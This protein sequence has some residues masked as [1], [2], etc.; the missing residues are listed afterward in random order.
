MTLAIGWDERSAYWVS[1]RAYFLYTEGRCRESLA[2]LEG[3]MEL[4]PDNL[5]YKDSAS[6]LHL[7][8]GNPGQAIRYAS[9]VISADPENI[10]ALVRRC[11]G[12]L[13]LGKSSEAR[14]DVARMNLLGATLHVRRIEMRLQVVE[15]FGRNSV[16]EK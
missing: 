8:L 11:E 6:A 9:D 1:E 10:N 5:Y 3:L 2:L 12:Y 7:A 15:K 14:R 16:R 13:H 4:D